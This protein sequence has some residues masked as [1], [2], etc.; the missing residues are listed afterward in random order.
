MRYISACKHVLA[1]ELIVTMDNVSQDVGHVRASNARTCPSYHSA[2]E[3]IGRRWNGVIIQRL[4]SGPE[5]FSELRSGIPGITDAMLTQRLRQLEG[6]GIVSRE[7]LTT[8]PVEIRY[9]LTGVGERL[10]PILD[11][12]AVWS[13]AWASIDA[14][15]DTSAE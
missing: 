15:V 5:R 14:H 3:L 9:A 7:V 10:G 1:M 8:R 13:N 6:E 2:I 4:L 12:V 11:A